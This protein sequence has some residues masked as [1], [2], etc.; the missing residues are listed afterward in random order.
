MAKRVKKSAVKTK[1][2]L[3]D[4]TLRDGG[5][6]EG[7]TFSVADKLKI[8]HL[9]DDFGFDYIE[10]G[11]PGSNPKDKEYFETMKRRK[12]KRAKLAAFTMTKRKGVKVK[13]DKILAEV[14]AA[15]TPVVTVFGK[16]WG[17]HVR[18]ALGITEKENLELIMIGPHENYY[19][20]LKSF[21]KN[22]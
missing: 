3:Y 11:W 12:L 16:A 8:T 22:R 9:L 7:I 4:T 21:L 17:L 18:E 14:I 1:L 10:G 15:K 2:R 19:R 6:A 20:D 13:D 5:Q